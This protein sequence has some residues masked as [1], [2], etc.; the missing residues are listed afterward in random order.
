[1]FRNLVLSGGR[2]AT[3]VWGYAPAA[4]LRSW[5]ISR[6]SQASGGDGSWRLLAVLESV[7][8]YH[9]RQRPLLFSAPRKGGAWCFPIEAIDGA[10]IAR[11]DA[12]GDLTGA[13]FSARLGPPEF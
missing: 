6:D 1:V 4:V 5:R 13:G 9:V 2:G 12:G 10:T 11:L 7:N 8:R 3:L